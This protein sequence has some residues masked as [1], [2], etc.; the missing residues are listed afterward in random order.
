MLRLTLL[1]LIVFAAMVKA[2]AATSSVKATSQTTAKAEEV[3]ETQSKD[4]SVSTDLSFNSNLKESTSDESEQYL[5]LGITPIYKVNKN[6]NLS[7]AI[8]VDHTL[9]GFQ[10]TT[11]NNTAVSLSQS[12]EL[13]PTLSRKFTMTTLLPTNGEANEKSS[14]RTA[15]GFGASLSKQTSFMKKDTSLSI[16][17]SVLKYIHD[18]TSNSD[19]KANTSERL[20]LQASAGMALSKKLNLNLLGRYDLGQTYDA[21]LKTKF[22]LSPWV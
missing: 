14:L 10:D 12:K 7:A 19:L 8:S 22:L 2:K 20:R 9:T 1:I 6:V 17:S 15:L 13:S 3:K 5:A 11:L 21:V 18:Y 16:G 4:L